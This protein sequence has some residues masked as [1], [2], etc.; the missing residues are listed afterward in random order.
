MNKYRLRFTKSFEN[1]YI[2]LLKK[3]R[4]LKEKV[5]RTLEILKN[6]PFNPSLKTHK[7][8]S[9]NVG[10]AFAS[11]V[12]GDIRIIWHFDKFEILVIILLDIGGH[13]GSRKVYS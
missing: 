13:S 12:T 4:Q 6:N 11:G 8:V 2:K 1:R 5:D 9:R 7:V 3:N 10:E